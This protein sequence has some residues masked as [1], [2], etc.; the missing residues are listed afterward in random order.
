MQTLTSNE[1]LGT[2]GGNEPT[3][4]DKDSVGNF[5]LCW[6]E[7]VLCCWVSKAN[8]ELLY[9][10]QAVGYESFATNDNESSLYR[11]SLKYETNISEVWNF[12]FRQ[13]SVN[14]DTTIM[15]RF[16]CWRFEDVIVPDCQWASKTWRTRTEVFH[17]YEATFRK[18]LTA[19]M[20]IVVMVMVTRRR[21]RMTM[22]TTTT[23][24]MMMVMVMVM[25]MIIVMMLMVVVMIMRMITTKIELGFYL[26]QYHASLGIMKT[27]H[28]YS[29]SIPPFLFQVPLVMH[30]CVVNKRF[31]Y[32]SRLQHSYTPQMAPKN[33]LTAALE[34]QEQ[35]NFLFTGFQRT[36]SNAFRLKAITLFIECGMFNRGSNSIDITRHETSRWDGFQWGP[37]VRKLKQTWFA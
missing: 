6:C 19:A 18:K 2:S 34:G 32:F 20:V 17:L 12:W 5:F 31:A 23:T 28:D 30:P 33:V 1:Y 29:L 37:L 13:L 21:M 8:T 24:M 22:T 26:F 36:G 10:L 14:D 27:N 16:P 11:K 15:K 7:V 25:M 9:E 4:L 35:S 3:E